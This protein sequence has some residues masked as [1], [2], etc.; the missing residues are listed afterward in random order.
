MRKIFTIRYEYAVQKITEYR[1]CQ[2]KGNEDCPRK[3]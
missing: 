1:Y 2:D 3:G